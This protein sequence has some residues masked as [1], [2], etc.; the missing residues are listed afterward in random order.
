MLGIEDVKRLLTELEA[1]NESQM[2]NDWA[3]E[4]DLDPEMI[5]FV[6]NKIVEYSHMLCVQIAMTKIEEEEAEFVMRKDEDGDPMMGVA[7]SMDELMGAAV[8]NGFAL[9]WEIAHQFGPIT[10]MPSI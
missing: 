4:R 2:S 6:V 5:V 8:F 1:A 10:E 3:Q 7:I 9:G